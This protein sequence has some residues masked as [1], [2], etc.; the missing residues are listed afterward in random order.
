LLRI[1]QKNNKLGN[2]NANSQIL[3]NLNLL[4]N[5]I[6][7]TFNFDYKFD[8]IHNN[9]YMNNQNYNNKNNTHIIKESENTDNKLKK[10]YDKTLT[11][12]SY[13]YENS[14]PSR[15]KK[16]IDCTIEI[17]ENLTE[18]LFLSAIN[19]ENFKEFPSFYYNKISNGNNDYINNENPN[20]LN[21]NP[22]G[23][24]HEFEENIINENLDRS[25]IKNNLEVFNQDTIIIKKNDNIRENTN[26][27]QINV[28]KSQNLITSLG[29]NSYDGVPNINNDFFALQ[30][31]NQKLSNDNSIQVELNIL[32]Q[33]NMKK[34][35]KK[36]VKGLKEDNEISLN[37]YQLMI[38]YLNTDLKISGEIQ[39]VSIQNL[40]K[41]KIINESVNFVLKSFI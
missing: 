7:S 24:E 36:K 37:F 17:N 25:D 5:N 1:N 3:T 41:K 26:V 28:S 18:N 35:N 23:E 11:E 21:L 14:L 27:N 20:Y 29:K 19:F 4:P 30:N 32:N 38:N 33:N 22:I 34:E 12:H 39:N 6:D 9:S 10:S 15:H 31:L 8:S 40:M 13:E 2:S 16:K